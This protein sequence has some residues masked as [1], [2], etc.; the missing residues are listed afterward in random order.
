MEEIRV[1]G[2]GHAVVENL[3]NTCFALKHQ[4]EFFLVDAGG[5][6]QIL[7]HLKKMKVDLNHIHHFFISHAHTDHL[8][9]AIWV[10]RMLSYSMVR[11]I[12]EGELNIY[13]CKEVCDLLE[14][15]YITMMDGPFK[16]LVG[17]KI[18]FHEIVDG[19]KEFFLDEEVT[20]FDIQA[21]KKTQFGFTL[22]NTK[23]IFAGDEPFNDACDHYASGMKILC[24]EA[25]C[26]YASREIFHPERAGHSTPLTAGAT[27]S[28][29]GMEK[30][31]LW[32]TEDQS[33]NKKEV[34]QKEAESVFDGEVIVPLDD[35]VI[36]L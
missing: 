12:Y 13:G 36:S 8:T 34:Y 33:I 17:T 31:I 6:S 28:R 15:M 19:Q 16:K 24:H 22:S 4:D 5:G 9:G 1:F 29:L 10:L 30:L 20:F 25:F 27:A 11:G 3:Y 7:T 32:H 23:L 26:A 35:E 2:T 14:M 18:I 21:K